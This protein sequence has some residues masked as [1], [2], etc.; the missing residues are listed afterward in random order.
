MSRTAVF[1]SGEALATS[2]LN[3]ARPW[4]SP[5]TD[6]NWLIWTPRRHVVQGHVFLSGHSHGDRAAFLMK[7]KYLDKKKKQ[8]PPRSGVVQL[9]EKAHWSDWLKLRQWNELFCSEKWIH[10]FID[11]TFTM[12]SNCCLSSGSVSSEGPGLCGLWRRVLQRPC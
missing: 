11:R 3:S 2:W 8:K 12:S 4:L 6:D 1:L 9:I 10:H 5:S 7:Q